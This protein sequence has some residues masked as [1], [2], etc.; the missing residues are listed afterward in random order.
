MF[1]VQL[2]DALALAKCDS[3]ENM[4]QYLPQALGDNTKWFAP[5]LRTFTSWSAMEDAFLKQFKVDINVVLSELDTLRMDNWDV[6][7]YIERF[8]LKTTRLP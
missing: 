8:N 3:D 2:K 7:A 5:Q 6:D 1:L 4:L